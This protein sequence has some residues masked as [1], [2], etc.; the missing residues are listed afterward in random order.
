MPLTNNDWDTQL[1]D[2]YQSA[3][4]Q[5]LQTYIENEYASQTVYP[6][7]DKLYQALKNTPYHQVTT[8][9]LGQD[10]YHG[11]N[12]AN[13]MSFSIDDITAKFPPSLRNIFK[14]LE[15][16]L[17]IS[18]SNTDLSDWAAQGVL[19]LNTVLSVRQ[20]QAGSHRG[21]GWEEFTD[22]IIREL[23]TKDEQVIFVLWGND[24]KKKQAL[25]TNEQH[26]VITGVHPSPLSAN[27]GFFGSKPFSQ[28]NRYLLDAGKEEINW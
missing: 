27:R 10:P 12:Q 1:A 26:K 15:S 21:H 19:L 3:N 7:Q 6:P 4:F 25:I 22:A 8:V 9:I 28:I 20:G 5:Q 2:I 11:P 17:G 23:N 18:R 24:A 13:G 14:E 16:D